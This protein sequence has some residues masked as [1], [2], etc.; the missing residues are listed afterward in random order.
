MLSNQ[1]AN[2]TDFNVLGFFNSIQSLQHQAAAENIY[3]LLK[4]VETAFEVLPPS[5]LGDTFLTLHEVMECEMDLN[6]DNNCKML[7]LKK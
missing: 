2:S 4:A 3:D 5:K 1:S 7:H 6:C